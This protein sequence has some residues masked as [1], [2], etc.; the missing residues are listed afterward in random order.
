MSNKYILAGEQYLKACT[1]HGLAHSYD[2]SVSKYVK[3]YPEVTGY[4]IKYFCDNYDELPSNFIKAADKLVKIQDKK[5]GGYTTFDNSNLLFSFD[6]S[7]IL[8]GLCAL[9]EKTNEN[10]YKFAA[11]K[12]GNFLLKMQMEN[13]A[14]APTY[15]R[16]TNEIIINKSLYSIWNGPWSGLMCKLTEGFLALYE[17]TS[18]NKYLDAKEKTANFYVNADYIEC[19]HPLGYWLEGLYAAGKTEKVK[20]ILEEKVIPRIQDNG[21]I[22]YKED[23]KYAYVSGCIQLG[24]LLYKMGYIKE[25][26]RI[27]NYGRLV[28]SK[29]TSGGLFQYADSHGNLDHHI[30]A[31]INSWGTKYFCQLERL[32]N[33]VNK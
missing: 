3:P 23:L 14:I 31:E 20:Q 4:V 1:F 8:I 7:Q 6:T 17:L 11:I 32:M 9:F 13:G 24:I 27:R 16:T 25:A 26:E 18:D 28:Q 19:T 15:D 12:A 10:K 21:Y 5:A 29:Y 22:P 30:H 2:V 33:G